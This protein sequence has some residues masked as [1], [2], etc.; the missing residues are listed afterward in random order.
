MEQ[1][2]F[3]VELSSFEKFGVPLPQDA[4]IVQG[5]FDTINLQYEK[6]Q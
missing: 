3:S 4:K 1:L 6:N 2:F 5:T